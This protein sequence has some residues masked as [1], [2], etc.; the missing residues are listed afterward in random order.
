MKVKSLR[1]LCVIFDDLSVF[2]DHIVYVWSLWSYDEEQKQDF[3]FFTF[4]S[5]KERVRL[6]RNRERGLLC[7][8]F[9][10]LFDFCWRNP[11][12]VILLH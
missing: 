2:R 10:V 11:G 1:I 8:A 9:R 12:V 7:G 4:G 3:S 6:W 5:L